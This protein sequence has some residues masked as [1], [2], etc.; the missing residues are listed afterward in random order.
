ME[1]RKQ[2]HWIWNSYAWPCRT[3]L[4]GEVP[5]FDWMRQGIGKRKLS[6]LL[7]IGGWQSRLD[8]R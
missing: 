2:G 1:D 5:M 7:G 3:L 8:V 4:F 6:V